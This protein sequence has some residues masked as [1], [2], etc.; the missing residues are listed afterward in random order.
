MPSLPDDANLSNMSDEPL[1]VQSV[2]QE[3]DQSE[4]K[5]TEEEATG[6]SVGATSEPMTHYFAAN[7]AFSPF[8]M[9]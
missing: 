5:G 8:R 3:V 4:E 6:I 1:Y 9:I 2:V 7:R